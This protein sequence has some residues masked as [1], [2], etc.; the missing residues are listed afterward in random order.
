[1]PSRIW[2]IPGLYRITAKLDILCHFCY[3][4]LTS[5]N[6]KDLFS[7]MKI[8]FPV[9]NLAVKYTSQTTLGLIANMRTQFRVGFLFILGGLVVHLIVLV[10]LFEWNLF[11]SN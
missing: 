11:V 9:K 8:F 1:M 10:Y 2:P 7:P 3:V 6:K 5:K 4:V